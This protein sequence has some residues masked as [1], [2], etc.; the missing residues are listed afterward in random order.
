MLREEPKRFGFLLTPGFSIVPF[1][2]AVEPLRIANRLSGR[3]LYDWFSLSKD[4]APVTSSN[5]MTQLPDRSIEAAGALDTLFVCGPFD[6]QGYQDREVFAWLRRLAR[7]GTTLGGICTGSYVLARAGLLEGHRCTIHWENLEGFTEAFP[8]IEASGELYEIDRDRYTC[9]GG[10]APLDMMLYLISTEHGHELA[11]DVSEQLIHERIRDP[12]DHQRMSLRGRLGVS[13]PRLLH[14]IECMEG[15]LEDPRSLA[16][17]A[18]QVGIS[19]R[20]LER[21]FRTYLGRSPARYYAELRLRRARFLLEQTSM[22]VTDVGI[23]CGFVSASHFSRSYR[24][25][26]GK[27]PRK[28]RLV[29]SPQGS[30]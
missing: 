21:L 25:H 4:G 11:V 29:A 19:K 26:F 18:A 23:A 22:S 17:I 30:A 24:E 28:A 10:I 16:E 7:H 8:H 13:H 2:T 5:G 27:S 9:S 6:P 3:E 20:Q 12:H 15:S 14:A 1:I